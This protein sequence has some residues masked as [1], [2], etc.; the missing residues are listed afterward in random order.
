MGLMN[1]E[2]G[3]KDHCWINGHCIV[4]KIKEKKLSKFNFK[5][6]SVVDY[7]RTPPTDVFNDIKNKAKSIWLGY[8]NTYGYVDEK[9]NYISPLENFGSNAWTIVGMFDNNNQDKLWDLLEPAT[10][11]YLETFMEEK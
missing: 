5:N 7:E 3:F 4:C 2:C 11:L 8:D 1:L 6:V 10:I 9:L